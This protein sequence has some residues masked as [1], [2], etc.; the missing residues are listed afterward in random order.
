MKRGLVIAD[1]Q[2]VFKFY[3]T[4]KVIGKQWL[5]NRIMKFSFLATSH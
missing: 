5:V 2:K 3:L 4:K 1:Y